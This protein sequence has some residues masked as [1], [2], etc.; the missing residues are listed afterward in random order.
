MAHLIVRDSVSFLP[1]QR[2]KMMKLRK[3]TED[4]GQSV[5]GRPRR[6]GLLTVVGRYIITHVVQ[7]LEEIG[8]PQSQLDPGPTSSLQPVLG[9]FY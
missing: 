8:Q 6:D 7:V 4:P 2:N 1:S 3:H 5:N 9:L